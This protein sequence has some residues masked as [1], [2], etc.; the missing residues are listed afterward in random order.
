MGFVLFTKIK[1]SFQMLRIYEQLFT[2]LVF[3]QLNPDIQKK[4]N[5]DSR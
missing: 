5:L 3:K 2:Y 1:S 4:I